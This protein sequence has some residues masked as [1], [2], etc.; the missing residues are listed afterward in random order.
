MS[1]SSV[2]WQFTESL[3]RTK[4]W[5]PVTG[6]SI[7]FEADTNGT[8]TFRIRCRYSQSEEA[9]TSILVVA[10]RILECVRDDVVAC[11]YL[12]CKMTCQIMRI[13]CFLSAIFHTLAGIL[14]R[15]GYPTS[16]SAYVT[17]SM[18]E[19]FLKSQ[20]FRV[21]REKSGGQYIM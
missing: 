7:P 15:W 21:V 20:T 19:S 17:R 4:G 11:M 16:R 14:C 2:L 18:H 13:P 5:D 10:L 6:S 9:P 8:L 3:L 12:H 1:I